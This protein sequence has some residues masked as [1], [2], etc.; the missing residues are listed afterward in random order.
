MGTH[1][2]GK[3]IEI[4]ALDAYVKLLRCTETI[5][6]GLLGRL[7]QLGLSEHQFGVLEALWHLGPLAQCE[8][9]RKLLTSRPNVTLVVDQLEQRGLVRRE[10]SIDDRRWVRVHLTADGGSL[11]ERIFP[12][13]AAAIAGEFSVLAPSEQEELA[14]LCRKLGL[15][16]RKNAQPARPSR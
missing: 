8:L 7:R 13:H 15:A 11:I 2:K 1:Y 6:A 10:R 4:R 3:A 5:R 14:R 9:G 12:G 16:A